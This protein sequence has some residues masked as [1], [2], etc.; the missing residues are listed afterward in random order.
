MAVKFTCDLMKFVTHDKNKTSLVIP[1][2]NYVLDNEKHE[3]TITTSDEEL[4]DLVTQYK[5][6]FINRFDKYEF[7]ISCNNY[8][9]YFID[10]LENSKTIK[11]EL[12]ICNSK[13]VYG[14][15]Q[16]YSCRY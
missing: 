14:K 12:I 7:S 8:N 11:P 13:I 4:K 16:T 2:K 10:K 6:K 9:I 15:G 3:I 1:F 5:I